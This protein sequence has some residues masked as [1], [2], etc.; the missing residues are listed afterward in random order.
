[1][2]GV[3]KILTVTDLSEV[4]PE[5]LKVAVSLAL[6]T[7]AELTVLHVFH[8]D[9][10]LRAFHSTGMSTDDF[11]AHLR[12]EIEYQMPPRS[13]LLGT[14]IRIEVIGGAAIAVEILGAASRIPADLIVMGTHGRT[15]LRRAFVGS[16]AE[17]VLR[18]AAVP[19]LVVPA[20]AGSRALPATA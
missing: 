2:A 7:G 6:E 14:S 8:P 10:Y 5:V 15:A 19:V 18:R 4:S 20:H 12:D 13:S 11:A 17:E 3:R 9:D 16:V 1:M